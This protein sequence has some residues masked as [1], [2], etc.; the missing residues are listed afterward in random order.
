MDMEK[1]KIEL[2]R[3]YAGKIRVFC[4][5]SNEGRTEGDIEAMGMRLAA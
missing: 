3:Y 4:S 1:I 2:K 5:S